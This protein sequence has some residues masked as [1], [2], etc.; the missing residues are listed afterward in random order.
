LGRTCIHFGAGALGRGLV[1]PR[2]V[3]AGWAVKVVDP[4]KDLLDR[5]RVEGGYALE[6]RHGEGSRATH[7]PLAGVFHPQDDAATLADELASASLVTTAVRREN[8]GATLQ[9]LTAAWAAGMPPQVALVACENVER[10]DEL[11]HAMLDGMSLS[12]D[13]R[14]RLDIP[15]TIVDRI[16][17]NGW[18]ETTTI[19]T[20]SYAELAISGFRRPIAGF[21]ASRDIDAMFDR[22]RYLVNTFADAAAILGLGRGYAYL[23]EAFRDSALLEE[24]APL[25]RALHLHL[26]LKHGLAI[27]DLE[28][29]TE[30]SRKRLADDFIPRRLDTVA[31]NIWRKMEPEERFFAP[32]ID[33]AWR[34]RLDRQSLAV[35][36]RLVVLGNEHGGDRREASTAL[37]DIGATHAHE[38]T[39]SAVYQEVIAEVR[40]LVSS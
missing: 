12:R 11:L 15:R 16:C 27:A 8:L 34:G 26:Q 7:I 19:R 13:Q 6:M 24:L 29:Y 33:L 10:V 3:A 18:P 5:L 22:K 31:R 1:L 9:R 30:T 17:A 39:I 40:R 2:L 38:P 23:S 28:A 25:L 37:R 20:E 36:A 4:V 35:T 14:D 21:D 32:L